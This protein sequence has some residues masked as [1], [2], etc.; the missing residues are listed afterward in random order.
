MGN[1]SVQIRITGDGPFAHY[2]KIQT[3]REVRYK[4]F[5]TLYCQ[6]PQSIERLFASLLTLI[7]AKIGVLEGLLLA[8]SSYTRR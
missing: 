2:N 7:A 4:V 1:A 6:K 8:V 5:Q 3:L